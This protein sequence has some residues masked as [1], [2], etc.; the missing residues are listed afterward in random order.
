MSLKADPSERIVAEHS[1]EQDS[2]SPWLQKAIKD[3][4]Y[5]PNQIAILRAQKQKVIDSIA[6]AEEE[7]R[8]TLGGN[9]NSNRA[10]QPA[11]SP[12][13]DANPHLPFPVITEVE[14]IP[15]S[16]GF[17]AKLKVFPHCNYRSCHA[18]RP[19]FRDRAWQILEPIFANDFLTSVKCSGETRRRVSDADIVRNIGLHEPRPRRPP[20]RTFDS[21][22]LY[23]TNPTDNLVH[24][25]NAYN[26]SSYALT[27]AMDISDSSTEPESRGF[28]DSMKRAFRG[29]LSSRK[30]DSTISRQSTRSRRKARFSGD[31]DVGV[32]FDMGL[33]RQLNNELLRNASGVPLP[34]HD[35]MDGLS[36]EEGEIEVEDGVAVTEEGVDLGTAD[37]IMSF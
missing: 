18:C 14:E 23:S 31:E 27:D 15:T 9:C 13:V 36:D 3:G 33:W 32:D 26:R 5:T 1:S 17:Q 35:G 21:V 7:H 2:L 28:R 20:L 22:N 10:Q 6:A 34:G 24:A 29:M 16:I 11:T 30:R 4:Q 37:I 19:T 12:S 8:Q 25:D